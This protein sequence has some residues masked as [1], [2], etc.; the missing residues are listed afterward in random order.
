[1]L[2]TI[3]WTALAVSGVF[4]TV[5]ITLGLRQRRVRHQPAYPPYEPNPALRVAYTRARNNAD[6]PTE[7]FPRIDP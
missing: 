3:G 4:T 6:A 2:A 5:V 7:P 1:M